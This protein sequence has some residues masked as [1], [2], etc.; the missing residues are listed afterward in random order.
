MAKKID[1]ASLYIL[2]SDGRYQGYYHD[3]KGR[4]TVCDK[5]PERLFE[6]IAA[7]ENQDTPVTTFK[8]VAEGWAKEHREMITERTWK[9]YAPHFE[10]IISTYGERP[11][12]DVAA[13]EI[14]RDIHIA[15][16]KGYSG[17]IVKTRRS[18]WRMI[19]DYAV[20]NGYAMY[21]PV[22][23]IRLPKGLPSGKR[24]A[25]S[26]EQIKTI[27][28]CVELPFGLFPFFLLCT[29]LRKSEALALT[30]NDVNLKER[31]ISVT[32]SIDY[33]NGANPKYKSPKTEAGIR[34]V[35]IL[36]IL[37]PHLVKAKAE[38]KSPLLF[39]N[40]SSNR[41]GKGGGLMTDRGYE[42]AWLRYCKAA[43]L[44]DGETPALTAHN[45]RHGTA[46]LMFE[47]GVDELT[48]QRVLGH[49]RIEITR[50]V[51][52]DLRKN[53]KIKSISKLNEKMANLI[54][55]P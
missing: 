4:H 49:S 33:T 15:K 22:S 46:T 28:R 12:A 25:P 40:P 23:S 16:A 19:Y 7:K 36:D 21:N 51:Y 10:D 41:G 52:T 11:F 14:S 17:T 31:Y 38:S 55:N 30:W 5:N 18:L 27:C 2:R 29:G 34:E 20:V 9:N 54:A 32:K 26:D 43:G 42:G 35:P 37:M 13:I 48:A 1:Y 53:Q 24:T 6:K 47:A 3:S 45:L 39:P 50:E 44:M 8:A